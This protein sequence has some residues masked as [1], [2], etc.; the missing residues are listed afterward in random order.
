MSNDMIP[1][2][3]LGNPETLHVRCNQCHAYFKRYNGSNKPCD[4]TVGPCSCGASHHAEHVC[5]RCEEWLKKPSPVSAWD[6]YFLDIAALVANKSKDATKVGVVIV[7]PDHEIRATGYNGFPRGVKEA[8]ALRHDRPEKYFWT[9]H[10][11]RNAIYHAARTGIALKECRIYCT[12]QP[13]MSCTRAII[14]SGIKVVTYLKGS[15]E[16]MNPKW[17]EEFRRTQIMMKEA[18]VRWYEVAL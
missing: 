9:E 17:E 13:C 7:G 2:L 12:W 14:Q 1:A 4:M 16:N 18:G 5:D 11:E 8:P 3:M 6:R 10:A 15:P